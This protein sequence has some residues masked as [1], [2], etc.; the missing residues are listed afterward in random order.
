MKKK[1]IFIFHFCLFLFGAMA[2]NHARYTFLQEDESRWIENYY[3]RYGETD[4]HSSMQPFLHQNIHH[5]SDSLLSFAHKNIKNFF[6]RKTFHN[7][8]K[9]HNHMGV[10][11]FPTMHA[12]AGY[13]MLLNKFCYESRGGIG[14]QYEIN[15]DFSAQIHFEAGRLSFPDF[16][17]SL[18]KAS[19]V[20]PGRGIAHPNS[21]KSYS[22]TQ[23][24]GHISY[25]P[26]KQLNF[27][28]GN[29]KFFLGNGYRSL[30]LSDVSNNYPYFKTQLSVWRLQYDVWIAGLKDISQANRNQK[31]FLDKYGAF[32]YLSIKATK[33]LEFAFFEN[34]VWQGNDTNR[35]RGLDVNYLNPFIF[36]RPVE[37]SLGSSDNAMLGFNAS[38]AFMKNFK[39]YVQIALDEFYLKEIR[40]RKGWW[41]NKQGIQMG[42]KYFN[43]FGLKNLMLQGEWNY[44]RPFT[45]AHGSVQQNYA[46]FNSALAH[47]NGANFSEFIF[48][49]QYNVK[50]FQINAKAI[51]LNIGKDTITGSN[52]GQ[53]IY[54]SYTNRFAEYGHY[55]GQGVNTKQMHFET[56][57]EYYL[58]PQI[59]L[60]L[61]LGFI[62]RILHDESGNRWEV[63]YVYAG[64]ATP[65]N[66][67]YR[68]Y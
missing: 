65:I 34:V 49:A 37:Y 27:T 28:A 57:L 47:P 6:L 41:A 35:N 40:A 23:T 50:R 9:H 19:D 4:F 63:P 36:F 21:D 53:N 39:I 18:I 25:S 48:L 33:D 15:N 10:Q 29:G 22:F 17:D 52:V 24:S 3:T 61:Q 51:Y 59:N 8:P 12:L 46:H 68:D 31:N 11:L 32:H 62:Q 55:V 44:V 26:I 45:Y 67:F 54:K 5:Y 1:L 43:A 64:I 66:N 58:I 7:Q 42:G 38:Y 56:K 60:R 16:T 13:D 2:Q 20:V 14:I 30:L